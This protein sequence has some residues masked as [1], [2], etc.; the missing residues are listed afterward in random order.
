MLHCSVESEEEEEE[1]EKED[2]GNSPPHSLG[3]DP[4]SCYGQFYFDIDQFWS[5]EHLLTFCSE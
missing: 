5:L 3:C 1:D 4:P 2:R